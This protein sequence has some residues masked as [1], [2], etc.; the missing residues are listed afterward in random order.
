MTL[1]RSVI[2]TLHHSPRSGWSPLRRRHQGWRW[3]ARAANGRTLAVSS[4][5]Y[6]NRGDA[7]DAITLL[8]G[9][10]TAVILRDEET[11]EYYLRA[12]VAHE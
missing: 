7:L 3:T 1:T 6:T 5:S 2:V 9:Y 8:F 4:E 10:A 11:P 12:G